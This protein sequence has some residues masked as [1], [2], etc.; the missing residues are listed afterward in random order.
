M[1]L[2]IIHLN[3][4]RSKHI[5]N[6][7]KLL[8][9][10]KPD[11]VCFQEAMISDI[12]NI[13][14]KLNYQTA[15]AP[16]FLIKNNDGEDQEGSAILS[17]Y[18]IL[19]IKNYKYND[20]LPV[21][22]PVYSE[23]E[24]I[25]KKNVRPKNRFLFNYNLLTASIKNSEGKKIT[26]ATTHFPVVDHSAPGLADHELGSIKDINELEHADIYLERLISNIRLLNDPLIFTADLNNA[27]GEYVYDALAHELVDIVPNSIQSTID[28]KLHR[29]SGLKLV[30]DTM[31]TSFNVSVKKFRIIEGISDHKALIS[32]IDI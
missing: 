8:K 7:L 14:L 3:I 9:E 10:E 6:V 5:D 25:S 1:I 18:S 2:K 20:K 30:V 4:E 28:P 12:K 26:V 21:N 24:P 22:V 29:K 23:D 19:K 15:F 32:L 27:R 13:A 16:R 31:M 17:K 11:I